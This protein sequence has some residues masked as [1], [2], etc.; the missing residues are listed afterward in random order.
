MYF[1]YG[2]GDGIYIIL[3][4]VVM[5]ISLYAQ[6]K[7]QRTFNK[8]AQTPVASG[9]RA[10]AGRGGAARDRFRTRAL[11]RRR[12]PRLAGGAGA[13]VVQHGDAA[14]VVHAPGQ[15]AGAGGGAV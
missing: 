6:S 7:V 3:L 2:S 1:G 14:S 11:R 12:Q 8:F 15:H 13:P 10:A 5:G 9:L 4:I